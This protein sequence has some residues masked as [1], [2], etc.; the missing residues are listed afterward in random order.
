M[1]LIIFVKLT[2]LATGLLYGINN[3][4]RAMENRS[5]STTSIIIQALSTFGFIVIQFELWNI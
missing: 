5:I 4:Y 3:T 1:N 2:C